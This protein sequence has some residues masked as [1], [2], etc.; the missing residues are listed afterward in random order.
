MVLGCHF[1]GWV[2]CGCRY[3][4]LW[5]LVFCGMFA[6]GVALVTCYLWW[7]VIGLIAVAIAYAYGFDG[8]LWCLARCVGCL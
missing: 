6:L 5:W 7:V 1:A 4:C 8:C 2:G 3:Y